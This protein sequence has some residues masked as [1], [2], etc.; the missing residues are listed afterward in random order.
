MPPGLLLS[1]LGARCLEA[2]GPSG[3]ERVRLCNPCVPDPNTAPPQSPAPSVAAS[4][5]LSHHR[6][7]SNH[8]SSYG[9]AHSTSAYAAPFSAGRGGDAYQHYSPRWRSVTVVSQGRAAVECAADGVGTRVPARTEEVQR[10]R[11]RTRSASAPRTTHPS[12]T[13]WPGRRRARLRPRVGIDTAHSARRWRRRGIARCR[14][15]RRSQ[16]KTSVPSATES[17]RRES[18]PTLRLSASRT[19]A[20]A[21]RRTARTAAAPEA[22]A[23]DSRHRT[24][25]RGGRACTRTRRR[26]RTASTTPSARYAWKSSRSGWPWLGWSA[27]AASTG[28]A[29]LR[30]SSATRAGAPSISMTGSDSRAWQ[31]GHRWARDAGM[32]TRRHGVLGPWVAVGRETRGT[33][34]D[35]T[36]AGLGARGSGLVSVV[37]CIFELWG[38]SR[39]SRPMVMIYR[40][41]IRPRIGESRSSCGG[42]R[43]S[44]TGRAGPA[45]GGGR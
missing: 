22:A 38:S 34:H 10:P 9:G 37:F 24:R 19:S 3:G 27:S 14:R 31:V 44:A 26:K 30:G 41:R 40:L 8:G 4:P 20:C 25:L 2:S 16:R 21:S 7:R 36:C 12:N 39:L 5:R 29:Y 28:R 32:E 18:C 15:R 45:A 17:C 6:S 43:C 42:W 33:G 35:T 23:V 13:T 11:V 1:D